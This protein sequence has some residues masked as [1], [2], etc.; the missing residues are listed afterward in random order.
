MVL[1]CVKGYSAERP[2]ERL[3][4]DEF[5][6]K[7]V[8]WCETRLDNVHYIMTSG[9]PLSVQ[10]YLEG[11]KINLRL[12][13]ENTRELTYYIRCNG[14]VHPENEPVGKEKVDKEYTYTKQLAAGK[15]DVYT[16]GHRSMITVIG[17][18]GVPDEAKDLDKAYRDM[19]YAGF[20]VSFWNG[21]I[22]NTGKMMKAAHRQGI[23]LIAGGGNL[24]S[25]KTLTDS[26]I[27]YNETV[28]G[29]VSHPW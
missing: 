14:F 17:H 5:I 3:V 11:R 22:I 4:L 7:N 9:G 8:S 26:V 15:E 16:I 19:L 27:K 24:S 2:Q 25:Y 6:V 1:A 20:D 13:N 10:V 29:Y 12:K 21:R 28:Y 18:G 23:K